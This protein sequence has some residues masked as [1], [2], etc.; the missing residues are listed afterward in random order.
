MVAASFIEA[1][2][3]MCAARTCGAGTHR[4]A[5]GELCLPRGGQ[6]CSL[7]MSDANPFDM[8]SA[9]GV[10]ERVQRVADQSENLLYPGLFE[11]TNQEF[12]NCL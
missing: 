1:R 10:G 6:R 12:R 5:P 3:Q 9:N 7:L 2:N 4:K 11:R 8:A